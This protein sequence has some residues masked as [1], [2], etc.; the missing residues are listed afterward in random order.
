M[1]RT[2]GRFQFDLATGDLR[3]DGARIPLQ[4]AIEK[5]LVELISRAGEPVSRADLARS[6]WPD[7]THV[8]YENSLNNAIARLRRVVGTRWIE[9]VPKRGYRFAASKIRPARRPHPAAERARLRGEHFWNR[10]TA[11]GLRRSAA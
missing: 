2:F 6:L 8:D 7:G 11:A 3:R 4:P 10:T 1:Q 5:L 9:T